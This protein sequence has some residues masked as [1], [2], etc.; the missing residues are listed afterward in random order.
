VGSDKEPAFAVTRLEA[1]FLAFV[2]AGEGASVGSSAGGTT[3]LRFVDGARA[4]V[5]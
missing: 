3:D 4:A 2:G 5:G 1:V